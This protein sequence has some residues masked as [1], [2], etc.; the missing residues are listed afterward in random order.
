MDLM[1]SEHLL[2]ASE[3]TFTNVF[4]YKGAYGFRVS[5]LNNSLIILK[6]REP[7]SFFCPVGD[8]PDIEILFKYQKGQGVAPLVERVPEA[9]VKKHIEGDKR[10]TAFEEREHFDYIH[11]IKELVE[12]KGR[13]FHDKR[14]KVNR[15]RN[16]HKYEYMPLTPELIREC[17]EF[18]DYWCEDRECEKY[19]GLQNE[20]KAVMAMLKNFVALGLIGGVIKLGRNVAA[21]TIAEKYLPDTLV[22]HV[23]KANSDIPGLYQAIN[24]EFLI[25]GAGGC[26]FVNREQDLGIDG[27]RQAK[28]S[29][30]PVRFVKKYT[31][32]PSKI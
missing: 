31:V 6:G 18:E 19:Y 14:N 13:R 17:I 27:L 1:L 22:I 12:L 7:V 21:L 11:D 4:A 9:F 28:M 16:D 8:D 23:E 30:N 26:R 29:Y 3:Y 20:K 32:R 25:H 24:Q 2:E 15:F 5:S 10:Y